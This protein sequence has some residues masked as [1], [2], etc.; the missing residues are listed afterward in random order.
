[1]LIISMSCRK[2]KPRKKSAWFPNEDG[3]QQEATNGEEDRD[4]VQRKMVPH[5]SGA[6]IVDSWDTKRIVLNVVSMLQ[7]KGENLVIYISLYWFFIWLCQ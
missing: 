3:V 6:R 7:G 5:S 1:M 4:G 2:R